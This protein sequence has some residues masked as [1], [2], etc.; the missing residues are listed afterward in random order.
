MLHDDRLCY[1]HINHRAVPESFSCKRG[2]VEIGGEVVCA[3]VLWN[4]FSSDQ[5]PEQAKTFS[6]IQQHNTQKCINLFNY[7]LLWEINLL[8]RFCSVCVAGLLFED[9]GD[10]QA[11]RGICI[12]EFINKMHKRSPI[13]F[14]YLYSPSESEVSGGVVQ[15]RPPLLL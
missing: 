7:S 14:N 15:R 11:R 9:K 5:R 8:N 10:K 1:F 6:Y 3:D 4:E 2:C 12:W 13:F